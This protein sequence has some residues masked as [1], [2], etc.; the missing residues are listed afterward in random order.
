MINPDH[1]FAV[2]RYVK[3]LEQGIRTSRV[4]LN[5]EQITRSKIIEE[6]AFNRLYEQGKYFDSMRR[7]IKNAGIEFD[8]ISKKL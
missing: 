2:D 3:R 7:W 4:N 8:Q 1:K 5:I 6:M